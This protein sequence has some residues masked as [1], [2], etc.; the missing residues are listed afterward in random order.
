[1]R[2][3]QI[4][5]FMLYDSLNN[6]YIVKIVVNLMYIYYQVLCSLVNY[7]YLQRKDSKNHRASEPTERSERAGEARE[8]KGKRSESL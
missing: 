6:N 5:R 8:P 3:I 1:M 7:I 4:L 2:K